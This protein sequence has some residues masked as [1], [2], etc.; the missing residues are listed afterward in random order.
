[1]SPRVQEQLKIRMFVLH[2]HQHKMFNICLFLLIVYLNNCLEAVHTYCITLSLSGSD[3]ETLELR[4]D[5]ESHTLVNLQPDTEYIVTV[6]ALYN[7]EVEGP[8]ATARFK[9]GTQT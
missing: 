8:A 5:S 2:K 4:D 6:I 7:G 3:V 9:I 1:M